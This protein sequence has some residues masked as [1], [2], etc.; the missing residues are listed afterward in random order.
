MNQPWNSLFCRCD[1]A[2]AVVQTLRE[3][4]AAAGYTPYDPFGMMPGPAYREHLRLFVAPAAGGW[5]RIIG[6]PDAAL[7]PPLSRLGLCLWLAL[8][9][10]E[11]AVSA[12]A[13][14]APAG[15]ETALAAYLRPGCAPDDLRR[16]LAD[17]APAASSPPSPAGLLPL[18]AL[19]PDVAALAGNVNPAQ[20]QKLFERL[21]G[22]L[23]RKTGGDT[24]AEA[25]RALVAGD[26]G[27]DWNSPAGA[28]LRA[29]ADCLNL[30]ADWQQPD[31]IT[32]RDAYQLHRRRRQN[33][34]AR[35]YPGD[36]EAMARV[37]N[38]LDYQPVYGGR[39]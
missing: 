7:L 30:P 31:F 5:V 38:A 21:G 17:D 12:S 18:D 29:L 33:P 13:D 27:P 11:A 10:A 4:L 6:A 2:D 37:P 34:N 28:R 9:G 24:E 15:P 1:D 35:L 36:A 39:A 23:L 14:G 26:G 20:A 8:D 25:A 32:L 19:P 22:Q 3:T 16:I